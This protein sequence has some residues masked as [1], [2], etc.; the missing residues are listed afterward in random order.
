MYFNDR[1]LRFLGFG[2]FFFFSKRTLTRVRVFVY[3]GPIAPVPLSMEKKKIKK[4]KKKK[5][6]KTQ[7]KKTG[8]DGVRSIL[9]KNEC[10]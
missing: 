1:R 10:P 2:G 6:K 9:E 7:E 4:P 3:T 5:M 8:N